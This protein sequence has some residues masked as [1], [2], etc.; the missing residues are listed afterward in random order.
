MRRTI[1]SWL[2][3]MSTIEVVLKLEKNDKNWLTGVKGIFETR[4]S[5]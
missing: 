3:E 1:N 4:L 2:Y 5:C